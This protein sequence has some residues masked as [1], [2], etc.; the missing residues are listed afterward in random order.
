M[1][2]IL[3]LFI[4]VASFLFATANPVDKATALKVAK[5]FMSVVLHKNPSQV[6]FNNEYDFKF[7]GQVTMYVFAG[8]NNFVIVAAD[9]NVEPILAFSYDNSI[10]L[11]TSNKSLKWWLEG[12]SQQILQA[13]KE[14]QR[15]KIALQWQKLLSGQYKIPNYKDPTYL[16]QSTWNQM[17]GDDTY[18]YNYFCPDQTPVGCVAT[19]AAQI[20]RYWEYPEH[21]YGWHSYY[22]PKFG[23]IHANFDTTYYHWDNMPLQ[24]SSYDVALL[25]FHVGVA[26]DMYY[27]QKGSGSYIY[28]LTYALANYFGYSQDIMFYSRSYIEQN[29]GGEQAW[30]DTLINQINLGRPLVYAGYDRNFGG[31]AFVC[32]GYD[33]ATDKFHFNWGWG[34]GPDNGNGF[35]SIDDLSVQGYAFNYGHR[36]VINIHP[37][38][39]APQFYVTTTQGINEFTDISFIKGADDKVAYAVGGDANTL[40]KSINSGGNWQRVSLGSDFAGYQASMVEPVNEDT[41]FVPVFSTTGKRTQLLVSYDGGKSW[42]SVLSGASSSSFFNVVHFFNSRQGIVQGDPVNGDFEIYVTDD[43]GKTWTRVDG[44]NIPDA[45][46]D[47]YGTVGYYFGNSSKIWFFTTK[48]RVFMSSD[49]GHTWTV[50]N[51]VTTQDMGDNDARPDFV[52]IKGAVRDDGVGVLVE[53]YYQNT[54]TDTTLHVYYFKT[55]DGGQTWT[56]FTPNGHLG[57]QGIAIDPATN[58][59]VSI[60]YGITV[61][62]DGQ[63]WQDLPEYYQLFPFTA[64]DIPAPG[65]WLLGSRIISVSGNM[66]RYGINHTVIP[67]VS[68]SQDRGCINGQ[69]VFQDNSIGDVSQIEWNFGQDATPQTAQGPGPHQVTYSSA[70]VKNI[71]RTITTGNGDLIVDTLKYKVDAQLPG[72][73]GDIQGEKYP[74]LNSQVSYSVPAADVHY[75]WTLPDGWTFNGQSD[76]N[77][78]SVKVGGTLGDK[79]IKVTPSNGCGEGPTS[80]MDIAVINNT[81]KAYPNPSSDVVYIEDVEGATIVVVDSKGS[82]IEHFT[83]D[84]YVARINV[85]DS[86]FTNGVY[87][88]YIKKQDGTKRSLKFLVVKPE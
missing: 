68:M 32:D 16:V 77:A 14:V 76:T 71:V 45:W 28:S 5:N 34:S 74:V 88:V 6:S 20:M 58:N 70:G 25:S 55:S 12:Y 82:V 35:Y 46:N 85:A 39:S 65:V 1:K 30:K 50:Q 38:S 73:L 51:L 7:Q 52:A 8:K 26:V 41:V 3:L 43:G 48:G 4:V 53:N 83:S 37:P 13:A 81:D 31:H 15:P 61:S 67:D 18:P 56:Q 79:V 69:V 33:A 11:P 17:G 22:H 42:Q 40:I 9:D 63:N 64:I 21:G 49:Y 78:I 84:G 80:S 23:L 10:K 86:R 29:Y 72:D 57:N 60:G 36:V 66:W 19:A 47:E 87:T 54:A 27:D 59:F 62:S 24:A 44:T 75:N 2:K